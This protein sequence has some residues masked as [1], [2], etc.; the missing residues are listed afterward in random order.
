MRRM[1]KMTRIEI[2]RSCLENG[3]LILDQII[4]FKFLKE[5]RRKILKTKQKIENENT[6]PHVCGSVL[7]VCDEAENVFRRQLF[8]NVDNRNWMTTAC[9]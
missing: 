4:S 5:K 9:R 2:A 7:C 6:P 8:P 1:C 3:P